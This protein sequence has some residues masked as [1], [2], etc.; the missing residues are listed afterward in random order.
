MFDYLSL[1][2]ISSLLIH[3]N[4]RIVLTFLKD[5]GLEPRRK[6]FR[7]R[8]DTTTSTVDNCRD[9]TDTGEEATA[10]EKEFHGISV[11]N[12]NWN[13]CWYRKFGSNGLIMQKF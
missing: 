3:L 10:F 6:G 5:N 12:I 4:N 2:S 9:A 7:S 11:T 1:R 8:R 13:Y